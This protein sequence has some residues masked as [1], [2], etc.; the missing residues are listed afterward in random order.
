MDQIQTFFGGAFPSAEGGFP[1]T[2]GRV[3]AGEPMEGMFQ[4]LLNPDEGVKLIP[5]SWLLGVK[6]SFAGLKDEL[7]KHHSG[8]GESST[9]VCHDQPSGGGKA[10]ATSDKLHDSPSEENLPCAI[11]GSVEALDCPV[12]DQLLESFSEL[13]A[14]KDP[15]GGIAAGEEIGQEPEENKKN[16]LPK[17]AIQKTDEK[18]APHTWLWGM[19]PASITDQK[20]SIGEQADKENFYRNVVSPPNIIG[21]ETLNEETPISRRAST[22]EAHFWRFINRCGLKIEDSAFSLEGDSVSKEHSA[23]NDPQEAGSFSGKLQAVAADI[24]LGDP[25]ETESG[26]PK[27]ASNTENAKS[28]GMTSIIPESGQENAAIRAASGVGSSDSDLNWDS[29]AGHGS[30][31]L[32]SPGNGGM[33][34]SGP[35]E[36]Y[37]L[38]TDLV[39]GVSVEKASLAGSGQTAPEGR[40]EGYPQPANRP[41]VQADGLGTQKGS[42]MT[43]EIPSKDSASS[44]SAAHEE[45]QDK[46][47]EPLKVSPQTRPG[48]TLKSSP[49]QEMETVKNFP[50]PSRRNIRFEGTGKKEEQSTAGHKLEA[51][52]DRT[53]SADVKPRMEKGDGERMGSNRDPQNRKAGNPAISDEGIKGQNAVDSAGIQRISRVDYPDQSTITE[54][55]ADISGLDQ[56]PEGDLHANERAGLYVSGMEAKRESSFD[57]SGRIERPGSSNFQQAEGESRAETSAAIIQKISSAI[58]QIRKNPG[59]IRLQLRPASLGHLQ[60]KISAVEDHSVSVRI[61]AENPVSRE[62]IER[63]LGELRSDL[64]SNGI[65]MEKCEVLLSDD[66]SRDTAGGRRFTAHASHGRDYDE[67]EMEKDRPDKGE[68]SRNYGGHHYGEGLSLFA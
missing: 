9:A 36:E 10:A 64:R 66:A 12:Q 62:L 45:E 44:Y 38:K 15:S 48:L 63:N 47:N 42:E 33:D 49:E 58:R 57:L 25:R 5:V 28:P 35:S 46:V 20:I 17:G 7:L 67:N 8:Q 16:S 41:K 65:E 30:F 54:R 27:E 3:S 14:D 43:S 26:A 34:A 2:K 6:G 29:K 21:V 60:I 53:V 23:A 68:K 31:S 32:D 37:R 1:N 52:D 13:E 18:T 4:N 22:G 50:P 11:I 59:E 55:V 56:I 51:H 24:K 61:L 39:S 40:T 19:A